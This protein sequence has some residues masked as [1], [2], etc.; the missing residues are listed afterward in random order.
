MSTSCRRVALRP[1]VVKR[2]IGRLLTPC[3]HG[4]TPSPTS[5]G[6][7]VMNNVI[8]GGTSNVGYNAR[9]GDSGILISTHV[10]LVSNALLSAKGPI[11]HTSFRIDRHSFVHHVYRLHSRVHAGRGLTRHVHCGCSVGGMAKLGLLPFIHFSSPFRVVTRLVMN[12]RNALTFLSRIAVGARCSCPCGTDTV[13]CFGAVGR[14]DHTI[15][16]VGGL[17]SRANR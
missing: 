15:M 1:N 14:T 17:I 7:T 16:T 9:T 8:V 12:S 5:I 13:L 3:N 6:D 4:F 10:V 2:H 11:D